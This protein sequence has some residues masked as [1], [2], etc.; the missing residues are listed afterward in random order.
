[1][2]NP[3]TSDQPTPAS[4]SSSSESSSQPQPQS[5]GSLKNPTPS[6]LATTA[7]PTADGTSTPIIHSPGNMDVLAS[8]AI[9]GGPAERSQREESGDTGVQDGGGVM[10]GVEE[11]NAGSRI[12]DKSASH[13][14]GDGSNE[15]VNANGK[16][17]GTTNG[18]GNVIQN[19]DG[20]RKGNSI[21]SL[22][23]PLVDGHT[24]SSTSAPLSAS[25]S[26]NKP[27]FQPESLTLNPE[28]P[29]SAPSLSSSSHNSISFNNSTNNL[30]PNT[31][32]HLN[33]H[34]H[35][36]PPNSVTPSPT[37]S[38]RLRSSTPTTSSLP[39]QNPNASRTPPPLPGQA[40]T[41]PLINPNAGRTPLPL[42][43]HA[44][45]TPLP[46]GFVP[47]RPG[48]GV[49]SAGSS[50]SGSP[51][52][53]PPPGSLSLAGAKVS[54]SPGP[55]PSAPSTPALQL[56]IATPAP[57]IPM[58]P[59][60]IPTSSILNTTILPS[61]SSASVSSFQAGTQNPSA[62][63]ISSSLLESMTNGNQQPGVVNQEAD[64]LST[65]NSASPAAV[66]TPAIPSP[67]AFQDP[68]SEPA[69]DSTNAGQSAI[70]HQQIPPPP[71]QTSHSQQQQQPTPTINILNPSPTAPGLTQ[72]LPSAGARE[73]SPSITASA[74][75]LSIPSVSAPA[76]QPTSL[77]DSSPSSQVLIDKTPQAQASSHPDPEMPSSTANP[78]SGASPTNGGS[79]QESGSNAASD[80]SQPQSQV[81]KDQ[82]GMTPSAVPVPPSLSE[83]ENADKTEAE[84]VI[85]AGAA[86]GP[87]VDPSGN[88]NLTG[89][90]AESAGN[91]VSYTAFPVIP[92]WLRSASI[93]SRD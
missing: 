86:P 49:V 51:L 7:Y 16:G 88:A 84:K 15:V 66:A 91:L 4:P 59:K 44:A 46:A 11:T 62:N 53:L 50:R 70:N 75:P 10:E 58:A 48:A 32:T 85:E 93:E 37:V 78:V 54:F 33:N 36:R 82:P 67:S 72:V 3:P 64:R 79:A 5:A 6:P 23:T 18:N 34:T 17:H 60:T 63:N 69:R 65:T 9:A 80:V 42:P 28:S 43:G 27:V 73:V 71:P 61:A 2:S 89:V 29:R 87:Q 92:L 55:G 77:A 1:M 41:T 30:I 76:S 24:T 57:T 56:P 39:F 8:M 40:A 22:S 20:T 31:N 38:P 25:T 13:T 26:I 21:T 19:G 74:S 35:A 52:P 47:P 45:T 12:A 83:N 90:G 68:I 14:D 81:E